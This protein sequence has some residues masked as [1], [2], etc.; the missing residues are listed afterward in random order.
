METVSATWSLFQSIASTLWWLLYLGDPL[1]RQD[2]HFMEFEGK[3]VQAR[4]LGE[5]NLSLWDPSPQPQGKQPCRYLLVFGHSCSRPAL[6]SQ[7]VV[8][9]AWEGSAPEQKILNSYITALGTQ[10]QP[11]ITPWP[12][13]SGTV[14]S[15]TNLAYWNK[16]WCICLANRCVL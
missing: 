2:L 1:M 11:S 15:G 10:Q 14:T 7:T 8:V 4:P 9:A 5:N 16:F 6:C 13:S 12:K 3:A